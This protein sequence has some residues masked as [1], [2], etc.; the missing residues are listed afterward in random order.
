MA[1]IEHILKVH[2][3]QAANTSADTS[4][5]SVWLAFNVVLDHSTFQKSLLTHDLSS[6]TQNNV[7]P[8]V[9]RAYEESFMRECVHEHD[10]PCSMGQYSSA[11]SSTRS[12][13]SS[14]SRL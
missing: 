4:C 12:T 6:K 3:A 14:A 1:E 13:R 11:T 9:K 7:V 10:K 2:E 8:V 5:T